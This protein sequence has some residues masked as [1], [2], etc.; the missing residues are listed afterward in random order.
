M[1]ANGREREIGENLKPKKDY[2]PAKMKAYFEGQQL[3]PAV[4]PRPLF[5]A[6]CFV[7]IKPLPQSKLFHCPMCGAQGFLSTSRP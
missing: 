5:C 1:V 3:S 4:F 2:H 7:P 6:R